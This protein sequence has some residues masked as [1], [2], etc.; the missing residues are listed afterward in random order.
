[1]LAYSSSSPRKL[2]TVSVRLHKSIMSMADVQERYCCYYS[3]ACK[4]ISSN[5][6]TKTVALQNQRPGLKPNLSR[7]PLKPVGTK[8]PRAVVECSSTGVP[9]IV[10]LASNQFNRNALKSNE[11]YLLICQG[12]VNHHLQMNNR[13]FKISCIDLKGRPEADE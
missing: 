11:S 4:Y 12:T 6:S 9:A 3:H 2:S 7:T 8:L 5:I 10:S 13:M 1:M